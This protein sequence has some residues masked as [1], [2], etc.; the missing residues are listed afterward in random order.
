M[1]KGPI[2]DG[3]PFLLAFSTDGTS[4]ALV[5]QRRTKE[6]DHDTVEIFDVPSGHERCCFDF[7]A[8]LDQLDGWLP[9]RPFPRSRLLL[10]GTCWLAEV[11]SGP[12]T[13]REP[14][15]EQWRR[16]LTK[17]LGI[18]QPPGSVERNLRVRF[19]DPVTAS[20]RYELAIFVPETDEEASHVFWL[21][22]GLV[23]ATSIL[24]GIFMLHCHM[25]N[26]EE[27]GMMQTVEVYKD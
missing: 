14:A 10:D 17:K 1:R 27:M 15:L 11:S 24:T 5:S 21:C 25:M 18:T 3:T 16:W 13:D 2:E 19:L 8:R 23:F 4:V 12:F 22:I 20:L 9:D 6:S 26:H 7:P